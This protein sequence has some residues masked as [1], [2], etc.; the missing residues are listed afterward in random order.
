MILVCGE[1]LFDLFLEEGGASSRLAFNARAGGSPFNV[2]I[3]LS[4]LGTAAALFTGVSTDFLGARLI[5]QLSEEGV[6]TRF[7]I[8]SGRRTT[9]SV[10]GIDTSG[11][12]DYA[13]YGIGS[14]DCSVVKDDLPEIDSTVRAL[15]FGSYSCVVEP[16]ATALATLANRH[17]SRFI[18]YDPNVRLNVESDVGIWRDRVERFAFLSDMIKIS[19]ED[20]ELLWPNGDPAAKAAEWLA[21]KTSL[22]V[23]TRGSEPARAWTIRH[24]V[25]A[26]TPPSVDVADTVGAGDAFQA[27]LLHQIAH[28]HKFKPGDL[29]TLDG[30]F[31]KNILNQASVAAAVTCARRGADLPRAK[32]VAKFETG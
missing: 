22:V 16:A 10:V 29:L 2:A 32:D 5:A 14:A 1:A 3:G 11:S 31:L 12:P 15:H 8:R 25:E 7:L 21:G 9:L 27:A 18:S 23:L 4:R 28:H 26:N 6:D 30:L 24:K 20:F 19:D 17:A 13:F